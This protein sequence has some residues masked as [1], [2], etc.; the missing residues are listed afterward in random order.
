MREVTQNIKPQRTLGF[1]LLL[2]ATLI[3]LVLMGSAFF[4]AYSFL[5]EETN[6]FTFELQSNQSQL[7]GQ[8]FSNLVETATNTLKIIP[9][10][11]SRTRRALE[12]QED[13]K[14]LEVFKLEG[15]AKTPKR[16]FDWGEITLNTPPSPE[17]VAELLK[18][19]IT[20]EAI[21][22]NGAG[23]DVY[24]FSLLETGDEDSKWSVIRAKLNLSGLL[25]KSGGTQAQ[26]VNRMG[27]ILVDT[28]SPRNAGTLVNPQNP[29]FK[30]ASK[31]P[32][33]IGTLEYR[34]P[35]TQ[36]LHLGTYI[37]PGYNVVILNTVKYKDAMKGTFML[38][39]KMLLTGLALLGASL[40]IVVFFS[41]RLTRP[42]ARLT[43][44]TNV[45]SSGNFDLELNENTADEIGIL[46][47]SMNRMSRKI[48]ELL[49]ESIEKVKIEQ[50]VA[51]ASNLQQ[52]LIPPPVLTTPRYALRSHYQSAKECGGD[53]WG[54]VET[55][56]TLTILIS[57]AT[58]HGLPPAMLTAA[59][60]GCF[61]AIQK[62][63]SEFPELQISPSKLLTI[64]NQVIVDSAKNELNMTM[65][66]A[67]Y[68]FEKKTMTYANAGH[69]TPWLLR[70]TRVSPGSGGPLKDKSVESLRSRGTRLG[71]KAGFSP[72]EDITIPFSDDDVLFLY[73]DGLLENV[74]KAGEEFGKVRARERLV[75]KLP[76]GMEGMA[77][78][79]NLELDE[80]YR[81]IVP[82][83]DVTYV[84]F[85]RRLSSGSEKNA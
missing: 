62:L 8:R 53:W 51:I 9:S 32:I 44:M 71:E 82:N 70:T 41:V 15:D 27:Q 61:S 42:L 18:T 83:D 29:L 14:N 66:I 48:K 35:E 25:K 65:F 31:S 13:I 73:T 39:E 59:A 22:Q 55:E 6:T 21:A 76:L 77:E 16:V 30:I 68:D 45:I 81:D 63:L 10:L 47:R 64:A 36:E 57:D 1:K 46:S 38:L 50:E 78:T 84:M 7:L 60:H 58:G 17:V 11:D 67:T 56:K 34:M 52:N 4:L 12:N 5:T 75:S 28:R 49:L 19:G 85:G 23:T 33:S 79:L 24:L 26:I 43:E 69:N 74:N 80:F 37:I 40:I 54:Y 3:V 2:G 20:Y 72:S